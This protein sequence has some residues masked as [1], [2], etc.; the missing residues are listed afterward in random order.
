MSKPNTP[1]R[2]KELREFIDETEGQAYKPRAIKWFKQNYNQIVTSEELAKLPGKNGSPIS[3]NMRR[4]FELRDEDGYNIINHKYEK[5]N[6]NIDEWKLI[7]INP[8]PNNKRVRGVTK[9]L[10]VEVF[11]RDN[12]RCQFCG[13]GKDDDDPF[14]Q[15]TKIKLHMGHIKAF[16]N[17]KDKI[18]VQV[19][20]F[21]NI[22][23]DIEYSAKDFVTQCNICNE[24]CKNNDL[25][26]LD[27]VQKVLNLDEKTQR[28]IFET[29]KDKFID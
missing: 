28:K 10:T 3:H 27:D 25:V 19:E 20:N 9:P 15:G 21:E 1:E 17:K 6:L 12:F 18:S 11:Q 16:K 29:L 26:L 22:N 7:E 2:E 23:K 13:K 14:R 24:G 8:N 5:D 4:I